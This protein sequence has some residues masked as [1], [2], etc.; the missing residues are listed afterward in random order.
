MAN[1]LIDWEGLARSFQQPQ[2]LDFSTP[3]PMRVGTEF[4]RTPG[5][6]PTEVAQDG[7]Q[8]DVSGLWNS[9]KFNKEDWDEYWKQRQ[10]PV[11]IDRDKQG[12]NIF[13]FAFNTVP[14]FIGDAVV[15]TFQFQIN[16]WKAIQREM[17]EKVKGDPELQKEYA[18][19]LKDQLPQ[20]LANNDP[21]VLEEIGMGVEEGVVQNVNLLLGSEA[22]SFDT[23]KLEAMDTAMAKGYELGIVN[24][25]DYDTYQSWRKERQ[26]NTGLAFDIA[27][28]L[29]NSIMIMGELAAT[30]GIASIDM[31]GVKFFSTQGLKLYGKGILQQGLNTWKLMGAGANIKALGDAIDTA[32]DENLSAGEFIVELSK[33]AFKDNLSAFAEGASEGVLLGLNLGS[34][35]IKKWLGKEIE[36]EVGGKIVKQFLTKSEMKGLLKATTDPKV[37]KQIQTA[38]AELPAARREVL[39]LIEKNTGKKLVNGLLVET[40]T[41]QLTDLLQDA[42]DDNSHASIFNMLSDNPEAR[43]EA[44]K[45]LVV[46]ASIGMMLGVGVGLGEIWSR[47]PMEELREKYGDD[48]ANSVQEKIQD[49]ALQNAAAQI[50]VDNGRLNTNPDIANTEG[51]ISKMQ[52]LGS[53]DE[54]TSRDPVE[55]KA[56]EQARINLPADVADVVQ[57]VDNMEAPNIIDFTMLLGQKELKQVD[58]NIANNIPEVNITPTPSNFLTESSPETLHHLTEHGYQAV[59]SEAINRGLI[60]RINWVKDGEVELKRD[61]AVG[62]ALNFDDLGWGYVRHKYS[63]NNDI[64]FAVDEAKKLA[65]A[66]IQIEPTNPLSK[67]LYPKSALKDI[68]S[69]SRLALIKGMS[70]AKAMALGERASIITGQIEYIP[71]TETEHKDDPNAPL[72]AIEGGFAEFTGDIEGLGDYNETEDPT[73]MKFQ[74]IER[75]P[76]RSVAVR[77]EDGR[78]IQGDIGMQHMDLTY[79]PNAK[80]P[81]KEGYRGEYGFVDWEGDFV[82][83]EQMRSKYGVGESVEA[84]RA[85]LIP[86]LMDR[87][88]YESIPEVTF[89][90]PT[91]D[92]VLPN[93]EESTFDELVKH[94]EDKG[95]T[96]ELTKEVMDKIL[97]VI[98]N[99]KV[100]L[101]DMGKDHAGGTDV[102]TLES[103]INTKAPMFKSTSPY[104]TLVHEGLH[105]WLGLFMDSQADLSKKFKGQIKG[106]MNTVRSILNASEDSQLIKDRW[107]GSLAE[108]QQY[109]SVNSNMI[110]KAMLSEEEFLA[111][112]FS[113]TQAMKFLTDRTLISGPTRKLTGW[114]KIWNSVAGVLKKEAAV[115]HTATQRLKESLEDFNKV[116]V[117]LNLGLNKQFNVSLARENKRLASNVTSSYQEWE[118]FD[119]NLEDD[120]D[121]YQVLDDVP[122]EDESRAENQTIN[123]FVSFMAKAMDTTE[124][125]Y[126]EHLR[127]TPFKQFL[128]NMEKFDKD[129]N[130]IVTR[131]LQR[132]YGGYKHIWPT[133]NEFKQQFLKRQYLNVI[134]KTAKVSAIMVASSNYD[135]VMGQTENTYEMRLVKGSYVDGKGAKRNTYRETIAL[136]SFVPDF[137]KALGLDAGTFHVVFLDGFE[138]VREGQTIRRNS[139]DRLRPEFFFDYNKQNPEPLTGHLADWLWSNSANTGSPYGYLY[140]GNF[141]KKNTLPVLAFESGNRTKIK[142]ALE[143]FETI[144]ANAAV[145]AFG[146]VFKG[147]DRESRRMA[148]TARALFETLWFNKDLQ[149]P[150]IAAQD[151]NKIMKR[152]TKWLVKDT[153]TILTPEEIKDKFGNRDFSGIKLEG[154]DA[155]IRAIV[156]NSTDNRVISI[157]LMG[158]EFT[159]PLSDLLLNEL[160]TPIGDGSS[161]YIIGQFDDLYLAAHGALKSGII[162]NVY[163]SR[164]GEP[165]TFIKHAMH[166]VHRDSILGQWMIQNNLGMITF[167]ESMKEGK[168]HY[169]PIGGVEL[170]DKQAFGDVENTAKGKGQEVIVNLKLSRF[171]RI[172]EIENRD[173]LGF[174]T[175]QIIN[176]TAFSDIYNAALKEAQRKAGVTTPLNDILV[177]FSNAQTQQAAK[178]FQRNSTPQAKLDLLRNII[179]EPKSPLEESV[180]N[181]WGNLLEPKEG[182]NEEDLLNKYGG[183]FDHAH[184]AEA[185]RNRLQHRMA[186][187]LG[188]K[189][190]G[191]RGGLT[192]NFGYLNHTRDVEPITKQYNLA[193]IM[194]NEFDAA[195]RDVLEAAFPESGL[196]TLVRKLQDVGRAE[197][198]A[199]ADLMGH[200]LKRR[201]DSL[202]KYR[203]KLIQKMRALESTRLNNII[204]E[205]SNKVSIHRL[206]N[207]SN[208]RVQQW[209]HEVVFGKQTEENGVKV[210]DD[211][212]IL[213]IKNGR[214]RRQWKILPEDIANQMGIKPGDWVVDVITPTDSPLGSTAFKVAAISKVN[215]DGTGRKV[216]DRNAIV[217]NSEWSQ[218]LNGK[219]HDADDVSVGPFHPDFWRLDEYQD[220]VKIAREIP[221][222]YTKAIKDETVKLLNQKN[223]VIRTDDGRVITTAD[224]ED[225]AQTERL[226]FGEPMVKEKYTVLL[227]GA[228]SQIRSRVFPIA[229][230]SFIQLDSMYL[231]SPAPIIN[232][233]LYHTA[234]S[235]VN[236]RAKDVPLVF[237]TKDGRL[238]SKGTIDG[239]ET[240]FI[241]DFVI[242]NNTWMRT[243]VNHQAATHANVDFP[244]NTSLLA[245]NSDP[246][247]WASQ[248]WGLHDDKLANRVGELMRPIYTA[249]RNFQRL[250]FEDSFN[251]ARRR[252]TDLYEKLGYFETMQQLKR[253]KERLSLLANNDKAGLKNMYRE[254]YN[255]QV[256]NLEN[257]FRAGT[258][259]HATGLLGLQQQ[260]KFIEGFIDRMEVDDIYQYPLFNT[261]RNLSLNA[262]PDIGNTYKDHLI[263]QVQA[264]GESIAMF[265]E[266]Y[267]RYQTAIQKA[268][269]SFFIVGES[270]AEKVAKQILKM[271][272]SDISRNSRKQVEALMRNSDRLQRFMSRA[273]PSSVNKIKELLGEFADLNAKIGQPYE[274]YYR[275]GQAINVDGETIA[276]SRIPREMDWYNGRAARGGVVKVKNEAGEIITR[277]ETS[278]EYYDKQLRMV[279]EE[280]VTLIHAFDVEPETIMDGNKEME[281]SVERRVAHQ[282]VYPTMWKQ[283][284]QSPFLFFNTHLEAVQLTHPEGVALLRSNG[285]GELLIDWNGKTYKHTELTPEH[286]LYQL[287]TQRNG[288]WEGITDAS[289]G[290]INRQKMRKLMRMARNLSMD[291]RYTLAKDFLADRLYGA[292]T[293]FD[294]SDQVAF[295]LSLISQTSQQATQDNKAK[296]FIVNQTAYDPKRPY[297]YQNNHLALDLMSVFEESLIDGW[298]QLYAYSNQQK[299]RMVYED[300][301]TYTAQ[302]A[303]RHYFSSYRDNLET[304]S[305]DGGFVS[306]YKSMRNKD[307]KQGLDSLRKLV[308]NTVLLRALSE[309]GVYYEDLVRDLNRMTDRQF[310][311]KYKG[312]DVEDINLS[313]EKYMGRHTVD[314]FVRQHAGEDA[315]EFRTRGTIIA[316]YWSLNGAKKVEAKRESKLGKIGRFMS[317]FIGYDM[318]ALLGEKKTHALTARD[319]EVSFF[320]DPVT[321][322][323]PV[324]AGDVQNATKPFATRTWQPIGESTI[325]QA[326]TQRANRTL[327]EYQIHMND[328][329][330]LHE[331][332]VKLTS[333]PNYRGKFKEQYSHRKKGQ[334]TT[335]HTSRSALIARL[336]DLIP[337]EESKQLEI[338]RK[339]IFELAENLRDRGKI[340]LEEINGKLT[341]NIQLN[342]IYRYGNLED[343]ISNHLGKATAQKK[344]QLI[345]AL[346]MRYMYDIQ[347][348][349][350][351]DAIINYLTESRDRLNAATSF[352]QALNVEATIRKYMDIKDSLLQRRGNY[353]PH[354][355]PESEF[356]LLWLNGF[357][358]HEI[359]RIKYEILEARKTG[360]DPVL[361]GLDFDKDA[362]A[363]HD[364]AFERADD[365]YNKISHEWSRGSIIPNFL[366]RQFEHAQGYSKTDPTIQFNYITRLIEGLKKDV[367]KADWYMYQ[368]NAREAGERTSVME[369]TRQ[370]YARQI[371]DE[372]L[373]SQMIKSDDVKPGMNVSFNQRTFLIRNNDPSLTVGTGIVSGVV[374]KVTADEVILDLDTDRI[375]WEIKQDM[376]RWTNISDKIALVAKTS[377]ASNR[378]IIV[379]QNLLLKGYLTNEDFTGMDMS[380][381]SMLDAADL[382]IKGL[383]RAYK[384]PEKMT[385]YKW[386]E[387]W[388]Q[389]ARGNRVDGYIRRYARAGALE[390]LRTRE[391]EM[392]N[393]QIM[394]GR[395]DGAIPNLQY[396]LMKGAITGIDWWRKG[397]KRATS[398]LYM[399]MASAFKARVVNQLGATINNLVDAPKYNLERWRRGMEIWDRIKHGKVELMDPDDAKLYKTLVSLGLTEDNS[400]L[401]I[402]LEAANI[403]PE[404]MLIQDA[405]PA[406]IKWL[407]QTWQDA[408]GYKE[409]SEKFQDMKEQILKTADPK[410]KME[411]TMKLDAEKK[412]WQAKIEGL[413]NSKN[414]TEAERVE[415]W[416]KVEKLA[417]EGKLTKLNIAQEQGIDLG[418]ATRMAGSVAWKS[419]YT[420]NLG[421][422]F[423][424]KAE[425]LRIPAFFIGY[426]TALDMGFSDDEAIQFGIN[427]IELRHA[428]YGAASKQFGANTEM[429]TVLFQYA[430]YQYNAVSKMFRIMHEAI[431]QMLRFAHN[432]P[433]EVSRIKHL[434]NMFKL[435][436]TS[437]DAQGKAIKRGEVTLKEINLLHGIMMKAMW[438]GVMMQLGTRIFYGITN[439]QDPVGQTLYRTIDYIITL[440][441]NGF[442]PGDD[443]D[444]ERLAWAIQDGA[445]VTGLLYKYQLQA[446][447]AVTRMEEDGFGKTF[448]D[449]FVRGRAED[450]FNF[451][452]R[453]GNTAQQI[454]YE[455]GLKDQKLHKKDKTYFDTPWLTDQFFT[456]IKIM[457]WSPADNEPG[458]YEKRGFFGTRTQNAFTA[459]RYVETGG[460]GISG[461]GEG[462]S[463]TR[464]AYLFD[465]QSY[466]PFLDRMIT[467][468]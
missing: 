408:V 351:L 451:L 421:V 98:G 88:K 97:P 300:Q 104:D 435:V 102:V 411:L 140:L 437:V 24:K 384:D 240:D 132:I 20:F 92:S 297:K 199:H 354:M 385:R 378:Q 67:R 141:A 81:F 392:H 442:D 388:A 341:Y 370:W 285:R 396:K 299:E 344:L 89:K 26:M 364:M 455:L 390:N 295:W 129:N 457:G 79:G 337:E 267:S 265:P 419:F 210:H 360:R 348:P 350:Y 243:N 339:E 211:S 135:P 216:S 448:A 127:E 94:L 83:R 422:G 154:S 182:Q 343:L 142:N 340:W 331:D 207:W 209:Q 319:E 307:W 188:G 5:K 170:Q 283:I 68:Q 161:V 63:T 39:K 311:D 172:K 440:M 287:F 177:D 298:L 335:P 136:E 53:K 244:N 353:M 31:A 117:G 198:R 106:V 59:L 320:L 84:V 322:V 328:Q 452:W 91:Y 230:Q 194:I 314:Q 45:N 362:Q 46:E 424:A 213:N 11:Q 412:I 304:I 64:D 33:N 306:F 55:Q 272:G 345:G 179:A 406:A 434:G 151:W 17:L 90:L 291:T 222:T 258:P 414:P 105:S 103:H 232:E 133:F 438:T 76:Y 144:Y 131:K 276:F 159:V 196:L 87:Y 383:R 302:Q 227:N 253:A 100:I 271:L 138:S 9:F 247:V 395:Y 355:F 204:K 167:D 324:T 126:R 38:L 397:L 379:L 366:P 237:I 443:D 175:K 3:Y 109:K 228:P 44:F 73:G 139:F 37:V 190:A 391:R 22:K 12:F 99:R 205:G 373:N 463:R 257:R 326:K 2:A 137:E 61:L 166:G 233:R 263:N 215:E 214:L 74:D 41:E 150:S 349:K 262:I 270:A 316:L 118:N 433:E 342:K 261:I 260:L 382:A 389:D 78:I 128:T 110:R 254:L 168:D 65:K 223:T 365:E 43:D 407:M 148:A 234:G 72:M 7:L 301:P 50:L 277:K 264:T 180:S 77:T 249:L 163:A 174:S 329:V 402:A 462:R 293:I 27:A 256:T 282:R 101:T 193:D 218:S 416:K 47:K 229:G 181:I 347:V 219:D 241:K 164:A 266:I 430:Q 454:A 169:T 21:N 466:I 23:T 429:G 60:D 401:A 367:L 112:V 375:R 149:D 317:S 36:R 426:T 446:L 394:A 200:E 380:Q 405:K 34:V 338:A 268:P 460:K 156:L 85:G 75:P 330:R 273:R 14:N 226:I 332:V 197:S 120:L 238:A 310:F 318:V 456:G 28:G 173:T 333:D 80:L 122:N 178:W 162:K 235:A 202:H 187:L 113:D 203:V 121:E 108:L 356:R 358:N 315:V 185:L 248:Y 134:N 461:F 327:N 246:M 450:T 32:R 82:S 431:P 336:L 279:R 468:K 290:A 56:I 303:L 221:A 432:R 464:F 321:G 308:K 459:G 403:K 313:I 325:A 152:G 165:G 184:T 286:R 171:Q 428:F 439:F 69:I 417:Q 449:T 4:D 250:L 368:Q 372:E 119:D 252:D 410:K 18:K 447:D 467:G 66:N 289:D 8:Y 374:R 294:T 95:L 15:D 116:I 147:E 281:H 259:E 40:S 96:N 51:T 371:N 292:D 400:L 413:L 274:P 357:M 404:D 312:V 206:I 6:T 125:A 195:P 146:T 54:V 70:D 361:A 346:D 48:I 269:M 19:I 377:K 225:P 387:V 420:S 453:T 217:L 409:V 445:L 16:P 130:T 352:T 57:T 192:P 288:F 427:A 441:Q 114:K 160:G 309:N 86:G 42:F 123:N 71:G 176:G 278:D 465:P 245:F 284:L 423:Q 35:P 376:K 1:V 242:R 143:R 212:G 25:E 359:D 444:R 208:P 158:H 296:G 107:T 224:L 220:L 145:D 236:M 30:G 280:A 458:S 398:L 115:P 10:I 155:N 183:A 29:T 239:E 189:T 386:N 275:A 425:K 415:A 58:K 157:K 399:G 323:A 191:M 418:M 124:A 93:V 52:E 393:L 381:L 251:L 62:V 369:L 153:K 186:Q 111:S 334:A 363:I 436:Q 231:H 13:N 49:P 201:L 305:K 255:K